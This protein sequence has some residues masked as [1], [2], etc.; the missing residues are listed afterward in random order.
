MGRLINWQCSSQALNFLKYVCF[1]LFGCGLALRTGLD[2][3]WLSRTSSDSLAK[4]LALVT[5]WLMTATSTC[6]TTPLNLF[7][8][9]KSS[10]SLFTGGGFLWWPVLGW[11]GQID[12]LEKLMDL[13]AAIKNIGQKHVC[14]TRDPIP[15]LISKIWMLS[16]LS[17]YRSFSRLAPWKISQQVLLRSSSWKVIR[18]NKIIL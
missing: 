7:T 15:T 3:H 2:Y 11:K 5:L 12:F 6:G 13:D 4:R 10:F 17:K 8:R 18:I 16:G 1:T 9:T 14:L